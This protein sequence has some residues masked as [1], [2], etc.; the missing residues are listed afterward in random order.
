MSSKKENRLLHW[1]S[2]VTDWQNCDPR[3]VLVDMK[4]VTIV[5][6]R[7]N[8]TGKAR[9]EAGLGFIDTKD[10]WCVLTTFEDHSMVRDEDWAPDWWTLAPDPGSIRFRATRIPAP[11][12]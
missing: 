6:L 7:P 11:G 9:W 8:A 1:R 4:R 10:D 3:S 2:E 5:I 12:F